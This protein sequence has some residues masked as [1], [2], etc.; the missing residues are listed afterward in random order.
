MLRVRVRKVKTRISAAVVRDPKR[1]AWPQL[2]TRPSTS[3]GTNPYNDIIAVP[4]YYNT[5]RPL[6]QGTACGNRQ[7][8]SPKPLEGLLLPASPAIAPRAS[9]PR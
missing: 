2:L 8:V 5:M 4:R 6:P 1:N 9:P 3:S 7:S